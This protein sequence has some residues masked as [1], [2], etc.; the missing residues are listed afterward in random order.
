MKRQREKIK[1]SHEKTAHARVLPC[2]S[3]VSV[4][5]WKTQEQLRN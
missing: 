3:D 5:E 4:T 1:I 2:N